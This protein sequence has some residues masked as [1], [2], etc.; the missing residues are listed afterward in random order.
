MR[1]RA[2]EAEA[3]E[4]IVDGSWG[5]ADL[6]VPRPSPAGPHGTSACLAQGSSRKRRQSGESRACFPLVTHTEQRS[7]ALLGNHG[8]YNSDDGN[9]T[10]FHNT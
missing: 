1:K 4:T 8:D 2:A 3:G 9:R 5:Q 10:G 6:C 7:D